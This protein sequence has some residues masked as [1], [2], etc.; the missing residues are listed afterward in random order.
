MP[1]ID[2]FK[3]K[4]ICGNILDVLRQIPSDSI[5]CIVTSPPYWNQRFYGE[6]AKTIWDG[7][8]NCEHDFSI[9]TKATFGNNSMI[10]GKD[11]TDPGNFAIPKFGGSNMKQETKVVGAFC[12]KCGAWYGQLGLEPDLGMYHNHLLQITAELKR[13]LKKTGTMWWVHGDSYT[14]KCMD[15]Q[16]YRLAIRMIDEQ[17]WTLRNSVC[18]VKPN[19]LPSSVTDRLSNAYEPVFFFTKTQRYFFDLDEIRVPHTYCGIKDKRPMGVLRQRLYPN[20]GYNQSNDPH[21]SQYKYTGSN[22]NAENKLEQCQQF[23]LTDDEYNT[24][25]QIQQYSGSPG[26]RAKLSLI[27]GKL[28][29][30]VI[31]KLYDVG[32]YLKTKLKE[33]NLTVQQLAEITGL[34]ETTIAHYFRTDLSGQAIPDRDT[35]EILKPIL[36]LG[37]YDDYISEEIYNALPQPHPLGKNPGDVWT[38]T[39]QPAP[40]EAR[41]KHFAIFPSKLIEPMI[42]AGC[43]PDGIVLDPFA[44]S[45]TTCVVAKKLGRNYIGIDLNPDYCNIARKRLAQLPNPLPSL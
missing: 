16:N 14:D 2:E 7:D 34:R 35:W 18:W 10:R 29:T 27:E 28:T 24:L 11:E 36:K 13:I 32:N 23:K 19:H 12:N 20:S 33:A 43:P 22:S 17:G 4:I 21:L 42:T 39:T 26:R 25:K 44:G 5:D 37:N 31:K 8:P 40:P 1:T 6:Q 41:G 45:G 30:A 3:N 15:V 9:Q 38:I